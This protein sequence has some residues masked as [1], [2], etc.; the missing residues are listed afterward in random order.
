[1]NWIDDP[2]GK[3]MYDVVSTKMVV[4]PDEIDILDVTPEAVCKVAFG[5][6]Y[7]KAKVLE[8]GEYVTYLMH[9]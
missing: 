5:G 3:D 8:V 2:E 9:L 4:P 1:M 7:Y 6:S